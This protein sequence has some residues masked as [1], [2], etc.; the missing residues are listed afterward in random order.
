MSLRAIGTSDPAVLSPHATVAEAASLMTDRNVG[1]VFV[2]GEDRVVGVVTDRDLVTRVL[3]KGL[4]PRDTQLVT[5]MSENVVTAE[6]DLALDEAAWRMREHR[7]RRLPIVNPDGELVGV[8]SLDDLI[9]H[10][11]TMPAGVVE[12]LESFHAPYSFV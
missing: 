12:I 2:V 1:S 3:K 10:L 4:D 6:S 5:V 8:V 9:G 11:E 7:V